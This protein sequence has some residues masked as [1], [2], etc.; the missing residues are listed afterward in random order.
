LQLSCIP[1]LL[2]IVS[3]ILVRL[4]N[5]S[6]APLLILHN[7]QPK[8]LI[9]QFYFTWGSV[10]CLEFEQVLV[11]LSAHTTFENK[12]SLKVELNQQSIGSLER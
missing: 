1:G 9:V 8:K 10:T 4:F 2:K 3:K 5:F 12:R 11:R 6:L 7:F